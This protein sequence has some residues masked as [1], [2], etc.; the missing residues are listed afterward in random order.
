MTRRNTA[1]VEAKTK[2]LNERLDD[3]GDEYSSCDHESEIRS[4]VVSQVRSL[5]EEFGL[6]AVVPSVAFGEC[7]FCSS[8]VVQIVHKPWCKESPAL[9]AGSGG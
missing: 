1:T 5:L 8:T 9:N 6:L 2:S 3:I 4:S 7:G